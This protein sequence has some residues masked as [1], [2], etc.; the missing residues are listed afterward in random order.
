MQDTQLIHRNMLNFCTLTERSE[1]KLR[2]QFHLPLYQKKKKYLGINLHKETKGLYSENYK[3]LMK[4]I[5]DN[6]TD[7]KICHVLALEESILSK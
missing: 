1:E 2:K 5:E 3:S 6:T 7:G 4:E